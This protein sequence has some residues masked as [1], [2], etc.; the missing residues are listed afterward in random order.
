MKFLVR[1]LEK[2]VARRGPIHNLTDTDVSYIFKE[3]QNCSDKVKFEAISSWAERDDSRKD[4]FVDLFKQLH[5]T[6]VPADF[7][8]T[9]IRIYPF[10]S[11]SIECSKLI[12]DA[13]IEHA[14]KNRV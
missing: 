14:N 2:V 9:R 4:V 6:T 13:L 12:V 7:I 10:V 1:D 3:A 8:Y 5:L 11:S